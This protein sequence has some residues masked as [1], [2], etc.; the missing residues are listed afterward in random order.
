MK[1]IIT[2]TGAQPRRAHNRTKFITCVFHTYPA[3]CV[4]RPQPTRHRRRLDGT[5]GSRGAGVRHRT[6]II[7]R[8]HMPHRTKS[9]T[10]HVS[11]PFRVR[12]AAASQRRALLRPAALSARRSVLWAGKVPSAQLDQQRKCRVHTPRATLH[13]GP[14]CAGLSFAT[15]A[16]LGAIMER[17]YNGHRLDRTPRP[18][19]RSAL[20]CCAPDAL[21]P[22]PC[23]ARRRAR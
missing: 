3:L 8:A 16:V 4:D 10:W 7:V 23:R 11:R 20:C 13:D 19:S 14:R 5:G 12:R 1:R 17:C 15:Y 6:S 2:E 21:R 18:S 22:A 9:T